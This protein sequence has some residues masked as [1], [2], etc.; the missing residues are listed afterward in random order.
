MLRGSQVRLPMLMLHG[1]LDRLCRPSG[2]ERFH[3]SLPLDRVPGSALRL[4]PELRHE[5]FNEPERED[6][7][8][9]VLD[10]LQAREQS[11]RADEGAG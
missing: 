8:Q 2:T 9:D 10:W 5:I 3:A 7:F 11:A 4:Y 1:G 6:V